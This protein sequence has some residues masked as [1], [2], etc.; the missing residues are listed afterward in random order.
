MT[1]KKNGSALNIPQLKCH[2]NGVNCGKSQSPYQSCSYQSQIVLFQMIFVYTGRKT[3]NQSYQPP[4]GRYFRRIYVNC[5][6]GKTISFSFPRHTCTFIL[7]HHYCARMP[8]SKHHRSFTIVAKF[9]KYLYIILI[10]TV[11][12]CVLFM[13]D[14]S[15]SDL[16]KNCIQQLL[17]AFRISSTL[18]KKALY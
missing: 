17:Q 4:L 15:N 2:K 7:Y 11:M 8:K 5:G 12:L 14:W 18:P 10:P 13:R 6:L 9:T 16:V 3:E 1:K